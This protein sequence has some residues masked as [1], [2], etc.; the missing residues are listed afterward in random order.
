MSTIEVVDVITQYFMTFEPL[1]VD[2]KKI[3]FIYL[4]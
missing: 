2:I 4:W 1:L 3:G